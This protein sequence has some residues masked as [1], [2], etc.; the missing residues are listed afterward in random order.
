LRPKVK[1]VVRRAWRVKARVKHLVI[2]CIVAMALM[3]LRR[4]VSQVH[5]LSSLRARV[6]ALIAML[7]MMEPAPSLVPLQITSLLSVLHIP[8]GNVV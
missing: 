1:R 8:K 7:M 2:H 4:L 5:T 6:H 3:Q